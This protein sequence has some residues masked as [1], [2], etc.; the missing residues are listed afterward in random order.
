MSKKSLL[1]EAQVRRFMGLAGMQAINVPTSLSEKQGYDDEEDESLG[2]RKGP[3][4]DYSQSEK[5]RRDDS[6]GKWGKRNEE[7][8]AAE[9]EDD[10]ADDVEDAADDEMDAMDDMADAEADVEMADTAE[11]DIGEDAIQAAVD[12]LA[13]LEALV[14]P[15]A[16]AAGLSAA[17]PE[18]DMAMEPEMDADLEADAAMDMADAGDDEADA[19]MDMAD[20]DLDDEEVVMEVAKRVARRIMKARRAQKMLDEA[21]SNK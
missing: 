15:L 8:D 3:E 1:S 14:Q 16:D 6:Y 13:D 10:A 17:E 21:L 2:M 19:E 5:D 9:L 11:A 18:M 20:A 12:A 4:H 7:E